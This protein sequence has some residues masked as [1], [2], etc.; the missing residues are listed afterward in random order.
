[1]GAVALACAGVL[2]F[3]AASAQA[4]STPEVF[5]KELDPSNMP[6]GDWIP[7]AGA[8]MHS[9]TGYEIGVRLQDTGT[10][11]NRQRILVQ[12]TS[13]P[14]GHPDQRDVYPLCFFQSG[15]AGQI[16]DID[17]R[18][19]YE[20]D[21]TYSLA[22]TDS[23]GSDASTDCADGS[24]ASG[25]F[26]ASAPTSLR[27]VG[28]T[29]ILPTS[30]PHAFD[31]LQIFPA[32][33]AGETEVICARDPRRLSDGT[34]TGSL[35]FDRDLSGVEENPD[36]VHTGELFKKPGNW[37]CVGRSRGGGVSPGPWGA[38]TATQAVQAGVYSSWRLTSPRGPNVK[39]IGRL[40]PPES[41]GGILKVVIR[42]PYERSRPLRIRL[43]VRRGG[44][45]V[46]RFRMP[47]VPDAGL[48]G[49]VA[50]L[51]FGGTRFAERRSSFY[52]F[53]LRSFTGPGGRM[54]VE[55]PS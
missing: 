20:G 21:G 7:L 14:D 28:H 23:T 46:L 50:H 37:G 9:V 39:L 5:L 2:G 26:T 44:K 35:V 49:V 51:S 48:G 15:T 17:E 43:R 25:S 32:P 34:L 31:G 18:V 19:L 1:V 16:V 3:S 41:A 53:A 10:P 24:T 11:G 8:S 55:L 22:V 54:T 38:P 13:V 40:L 42:N 52:G 6:S 27:F 36:R 47:P 29:V 30:P 12:M 45:V 4:L 33:G